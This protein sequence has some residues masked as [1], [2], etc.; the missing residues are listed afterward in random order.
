MATAGELRKRNPGAIEK[1]KTIR[2][3]EKERERWRAFKADHR[4]ET[5][6][7]RK[8]K[9]IIDMSNA[10]APP[11]EINAAVPC[12]RDFVDSVR[13]RARRQGAY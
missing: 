6:K 4:P 7:S 3:R 10:G 5:D 11:K 12:S 2:G 13:L 1:I 8:I 9:K